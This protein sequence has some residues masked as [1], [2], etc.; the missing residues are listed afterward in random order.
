MDDDKR[1]LI[2][3]LR[4]FAIRRLL[5]ETVGADQLIARALDALL[6]GV[7]SESLVLL[8]GLTRDEEPEAQDLFTGVVEELALAPTLP[9]DPKE[10]RWELVR[11]WC[12]EIVTG[13]LRP[14]VAARLIWWEGFNEL[15]YPDALQGI[16]GAVVQWEDWLPSWG[17]DREEYVRQIAAEATALIDGPWP[18]PEPLFGAGVVSVPEPTKRWRFTRRVRRKQ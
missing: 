11:W 3:P 8:A 6:G 4:M 10:A 15:G 2:E 7:E 5:G 17:N 13:G 9:G 14:E 1:A 18:P 12:S 16:V